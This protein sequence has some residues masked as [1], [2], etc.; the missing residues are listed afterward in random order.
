MDATLLINVAHYVQKDGVSVDQQLARMAQLVSQLAEQRITLENGQP[1]TLDTVQ[2]DVGTGEYLSRWVTEF[3]RTIYFW[4][5]FNI[6][7]EQ[8]IPRD[9]FD[10]IILYLQDHPQKRDDVRE[11]LNALRPDQ[12]VIPKGTG[13]NLKTPYG[14]LFVIPAM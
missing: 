10:R 4:D 3:G 13:G 6:D 1:V 12:L 14:T 7:I 11:A 8:Q 9:Q 5:G 2:R